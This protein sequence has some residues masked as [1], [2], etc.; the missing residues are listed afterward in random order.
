MRLV[1]PIFKSRVSPVFDFSTKAL[2]I[3]IS[4]GKEISRYEMD[5]AGLS[6]QSRVERLK[7]KDVKILICAGISIPLHRMLGMA[8]L[9]V[10]PGIVGAVEEVL[11]A[12]RTGSLES[13]R[14]LMPGFC[15]GGWRRKR[16]WHGHR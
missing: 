6:P 2:I 3:D 9:D 11:K 7:E 8:G 5:L 10:I 14:F 16:H 4:Q 13:G 12:Y 15:Q 1:I